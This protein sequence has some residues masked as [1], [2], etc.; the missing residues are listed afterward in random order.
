MFAAVTME[1]DEYVHADTVR[2]ATGG[3]LRRYSSHHNPPHSKPL[4]T[5]SSPN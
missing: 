2:D 5:T 4:P 1:D 3:D